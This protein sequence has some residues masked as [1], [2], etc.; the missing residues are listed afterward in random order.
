MSAEKTEEIEYVIA[1]SHEK[2]KK[3][4]NENGWA[5]IK[6]SDQI[7]FLRFD[8]DGK[9][10][11]IKYISRFEAYMSRFQALPSIPHGSTLHIVPFSKGI[12]SRLAA[13][14]AA[15]GLKI[16]GSLLEHPIG[17]YRP[18]KDFPGFHDDRQVAVFDAESGLWMTGESGGI[19]AM[20][21]VCW[22]E[23]PPAPP[24]YMVAIA[25]AALAENEE[26]E[27]EQ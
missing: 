23:M 27:G 13:S 17:I 25:S 14:I 9:G 20:A 1:D 6:T 18:M 26:G 8:E 2:L 11:K 12:S 19:H 22:V 21:P 24:A 5:H 3:Y 15:R 10:I 16:A 4:A 7:T